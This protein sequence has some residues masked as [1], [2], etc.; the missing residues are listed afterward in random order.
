MNEIEIR[1]T[2]S[3]DARGVFAQVER[4]GQRMAQNLRREIARTCEQMTSDARR[5]GQRM[6]NTVEDAFGDMESEARQSGREAGEQFVRGADGRLRDARGRFVAAGSDAGEGFGEGAGEGG[7]GRMQGLGASLAGMLR[8]APW[9]AAGAAIGALVIAGIQGAME[10]ESA[11]ALLKAQLGEFGA[12]GERLGKVA[13]G[14]F[15]DA[16]GESLGEVNEAIRSVRLNISGM[17]EASD[18]D[19]KK[20][21]KSVLSLSHAFEQDVGETARA[22][23]KL[24]KTGLADNATEAADILTRAF[25]KGA[26]EAD[27]LLEVVSEYSTQFRS[28]GLSGEQAMGLIVQGLR[29]GARDAD[30]VADA[31]KE[32]AIEAVAGGE[33]VRG[34]FE[35][36][37]LDADA[38]VN[39]FAEGG[40]TAAKAF[41]LVVDKLRGIKDEAK[42]N[43]I[44]IELFGTKSE[45]MAAALRSLDPSSATEALGKVGGAAEKMGDTL[46]DTAE[47]RMESFKRSVKGV[48][49]DFIGGPILGGIE[50]FTANAGDLFG[51]WAEDNQGAVEGVQEVWDKLGE[52]FT[53]IFEDVQK[54]VAENEETFDEWGEK[55]GETIANIAD[56][57]SSGLDIILALWEKFGPTIME[58]ATILGE[59]LLGWWS[60]L[61]ET[62]KGVYDTI[63]GLL[64]GDWERFWDGLAS[65]AS[66]LGETLRATIRGLLGLI[67]ATF[68]GTWRLI[69]GI[70]SDQFDNIRD[71]ASRALNWVL[72]KIKGFGSGAKNAFDVAVDGIQKVWRGIQSATRTPVKWVVDHVYNRGIREVWNFVAGIAGMK[73]LDWLRF[74]DGGLVDMRRGG[75]QPGFSSRD[76]RLG[77][78]RDGEGVLI[79]E[80]VQALGGEQFIDAANRAGKNA[81]S[82][83]MGGQVGSTRTQAFQFGGIVGRIKDVVNSGVNFLADAPKMVIDKG[84]TAWARKILDPIMGGNAGGSGTWGQAVRT[85]PGTMVSQFI[86]WIKSH[87]EKLFAGGGDFGKALAWARTQD[88]KGYQWGGNG[89]PSWDCSGFMSAIESVIRGQ[90]PHRRWSTHPFHGGAQN[91]MPGWYRDMRSNFMIGV[92]PADVG[93]TAGTLMGVPVESSGSG[94]VQV[95]AGARG[96]NNGMFPFQYGFRK[97]DNG[98]IAHPG[99][100]AF[101]NA[102]GAP[103]ELRP[104]DQIPEVHVHI[105]LE[106]H[107]PIGSRIDLQDWLT[108]GL[109]EL[110]KQGRLAEL[111]QDARGTR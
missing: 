13:G 47:N 30:V 64:T 57:V 59:T 61:W 66:G 41:D 27:D 31:I 68:R 104:V 40:P 81:K 89:N 22:V 38:M 83:V 106:N 98:M 79:P 111:V 76:N 82:V 65:I 17:A 96:H 99:M 20:V 21:T 60:G 55:F 32:F 46:H 34:G 45:D 39:K 14:L 49:V 54:F 92:T 6:S 10:E 8:A 7:R 42:R 36:L 71:T 105:T 25:Q 51:E 84:I 5:A 72:G 102:T 43:E 67:A 48:L 9:A 88:G 70:V 3:N 52:T 58:V 103:E 11:T 93:H 108:R 100:N 87:L 29:A 1:V 95:G 97:A 18:A 24:V 80:A 15:R 74:Q 56:A 62:I 101:V 75:T 53:T 26:N 73:K 2:G 12:E 86:G 16:Y 94:G 110:R 35:S 107:G 63:A 109:N 85:M 19:L 77:L 50:E 33:R 69:G 91:P 23:G 4:D 90:S 44:A 78:F 28:L 37:G